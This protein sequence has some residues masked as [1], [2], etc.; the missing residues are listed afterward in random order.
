MTV[1]EIATNYYPRLWNKERLIALV[2]AG[3]LTEA[4]YAEIT[5]EQYAETTSKEYK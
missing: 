5:G 4:E 3:K 1:K 2:E